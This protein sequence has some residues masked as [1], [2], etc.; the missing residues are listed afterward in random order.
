MKFLDSREV[1]AKKNKYVHIFTHKNT[2]QIGIFTVICAHLGVVIREVGNWKMDNSFFRTCT[3]GMPLWSLVIPTNHTRWSH[4][5]YSDK[6]KPSNNYLPTFWGTCWTWVPCSAHLT[7]GIV[8]ITCIA[9]VTFKSHPTTYWVG[10][11]CGLWSV[12]YSTICYGLF[13]AFL[14]CC[15]N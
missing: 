13:C 4:Y 6:R 10:C 11:R 3:W 2:R 7:N 14:C 9:V 12:R 1:V 8:V 5:K 15:N